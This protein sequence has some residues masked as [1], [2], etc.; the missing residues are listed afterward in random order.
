MDSPTATVP[1]DVT[2]SWLSS[3]PKLLWQ[4]GADHPESTHDIL[5]ILLNL[6]Q[7]GSVPD[8]EGI[9]RQFT[10]LLAAVKKGESDS[11]ITFGPFA[12]WRP[13]SQH[14]LLDILVL[15]NVFPWQ[16]LR[17]LAAVSSLP[18]IPVHYFL[19]INC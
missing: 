9:V 17:G 7:R 15:C 5:T 16:L 11:P 6:A 8:V 2:F 4:L 18:N 10:P 12:Q 14:R 19:S 13:E 1:V 3:F